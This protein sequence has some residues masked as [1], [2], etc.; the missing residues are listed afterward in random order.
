M[1]REM[2]FGKQASRAK[3]QWKNREQQKIELLELEGTCAIE[4]GLLR[5]DCQ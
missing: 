4:D 3:L 2:E 5:Y 1:A